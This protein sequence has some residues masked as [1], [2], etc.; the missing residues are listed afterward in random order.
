MAGLF[1]ATKVGTV[2]LAIAL[3]GCSEHKLGGDV[4][5]NGRK[6]S[7]ISCRV[8]PPG[9]DRWA[10]V[11][12]DS[13]H[14]IR[15]VQ[16]SIPTGSSGTKTDTVVQVAQPRSPALVDAQCQV[17][18]TTSKTINGRTSGSVTLTNCRAA[19]AVVSGKFT[20]GQCGQLG[21]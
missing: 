18:V 16:R 15:L 14:R 6:A 10:E 19:G 12:T 7:V 8:S 11:S 13:G 20:Y 21:V 4:E 3:V 1:R 5:V 2:G 9:A 17:K